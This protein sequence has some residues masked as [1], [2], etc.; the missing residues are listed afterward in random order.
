[1]ANTKTALKQWRVS[2]RK[3]TYNRPIQGATRTYL[4]K[5]VASIA[6][7]DKE[8]AEAALKQAVQALDKAAEK[9]I[10]HANNAARHKS[11]LM[12]RFNAAFLGAPPVEAASAAAPTR[13]PRK[14]TTT[15][16]TTT[17]RATT[18]RP[19]TPR[20]PRATARKTPS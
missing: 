12:K 15:P 20:A 17:P 7:G 11:R 19:A 10:L 8:S 6:A 3:R 2:L 16:R 4:A 1:M 18:P 5:A 9:N 14:R 13:T